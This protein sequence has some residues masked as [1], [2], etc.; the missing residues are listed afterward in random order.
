MCFVN[1]MDRVGADFDRTVAMIRDRL[2]A[3]PAVVQLP[4]GAEGGFEG[5]IDLLK[6]KAL[7][8]GE[9]MGETWE[10]RRSPTI[11]STRPRRPATP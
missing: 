2:E 1:K 7:V 4:I 5:V 11:S 3:M 9:G 8:W 6:M 10:T